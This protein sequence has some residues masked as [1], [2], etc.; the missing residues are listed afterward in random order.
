MRSFA[1]NRW[2][3]DVRII[4]SLRDGFVWASW[5]STDCVIRLGRH[6]M[7]TN[8]MRDFLAE[9]NLA[10]RLGTRKLR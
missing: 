1:E 10:E 8:V 7:I 9:D 3:P 4:F 5:A 6:D 2:G